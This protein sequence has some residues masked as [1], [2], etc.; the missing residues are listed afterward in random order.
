MIID[1]LKAEGVLKLYHDYRAGHV[2][3]LSGNANHGVMTDIVWTGQGISF[4]VDAKITVADSAELQLTEGTLVVFGDFSSSKGNGRLLSKRDGGGTNYE[5]FIRST[6]GFQIYDGTDNSIIASDIYSKK[7][8]AVNIS[9]GEIPEGFTDGIS[10]GTYDTALSLSKDDASL[11]IG[12]YTTG[13]ASTNNIFKAAL[14]IN[15]KLT[16]TEHAE[17]YAELER[18]HYP[19]K[20]ISLEKDFRPDELV[21]GD[22][23]VTGSDVIVDG[24]MEAVGVAAWTANAETTLLSKQED[25]YE[26]AQ[27]L[28]V[29]LTAVNYPYAYQTILTI[30]KTYRVTGKVRSKNVNG[31]PRLRDAGVAWIWEGSSSTA[32]QDID[33][34]F[35]AQGT[36]LRFYDYSTTANHYSEF[37]DIQVI[38]ETEATAAWTPT[39]SGEITKN[40]VDP[41]RGTQALRITAN[42]SVGFGAEQGAVTSGTRFRVSG[43]A[44]G[45]GTRAP[46]VW[47][48]TTGNIWNG[49]NSVAWQEFDITFLST[50]SRIVFRESGVSASGYVEFDDVQVIDLGK[51]YP[52]KTFHTDWGVTE[53]PANETAGYL[54]NTPF[55][56]STGTWKITTD[57]IDGKECKVIECISA[58]DIVFPNVVDGLD[59]DWT[60]WEDTGSGYVLGTLSLTSLVYTMG[61]GNKVAYSDITGDHSIIKKL[62]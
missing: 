37:D 8:F 16:A 56:I 43:F 4:P 51:S 54:S 45:D 41:H 24:D 19:K 22:M 23:E 57:T 33:F 6:T 11:I 7:Y 40:N 30:G 15:R 49:T 25:A 17:L 26:A 61:T 27:C 34:V 48:P 50:G 38:D 18:I 58:G 1:K 35:V 2:Q 44:R 14:I 53:S 36:A 9:D 32:W 46:R 20:A 29:G 3:D 59:T 28:R 31:R 13:G 5:F 60:G 39:S 62:S 12:N 52:P 21:D 55:E 42:G 10:I 47:I